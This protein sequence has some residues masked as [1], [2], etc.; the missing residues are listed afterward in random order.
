MLKKKHKTKVLTMAY[1]ATLSAPIAVT[2][3][4]HPLPYSPLCYSQIRSFLGG[5]FVFLF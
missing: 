5:L 4:Y 2:S 3:L 1:R